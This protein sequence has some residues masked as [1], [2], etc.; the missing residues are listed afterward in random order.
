MFRSKKRPESITSGRPSS[1]T[2]PRSP[3]VTGSSGPGNS[4]RSHHVSATVP[5]SERRQ[6]Q[7]HIGLSRLLEVYDEYPNVVA[8]L[9][10]TI[11]QLHLAEESQRNANLKRFEVEEELVK[12]K[13]GRAKD[14]ENAEK[15]KVAALAL[16]KE[17]KEKAEQAMDKKVRG[18]LDP[19]IKALEEKLK[20]TETEREKWKSE[21]EVRRKKMEGWIESME[22]LNKERNDADAR[23]IKA[24][25]ERKVVDVKLREL[26]KTILDGLK[27]ATKP[28]EETIATKSTATTTAAKSASDPTPPPPFSATPRK[29]E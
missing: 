29:T 20:T 19:K 24:A 10:S 13:E 3:S 18:E 4:P 15:A 16:F 9:E 17:E 11:S 6:P 27:E 1:T 28:T 23:E 26:D 21:S 12:E 7:Q 25:E 8:E 14:A 5:M 2:S 22:K